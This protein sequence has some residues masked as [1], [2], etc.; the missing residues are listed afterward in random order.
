MARAG[1]KTPSAGIGPVLVRSGA[2][3][4]ALALLLAFGAAPP[5]AC[6]ALFGPV[7]TRATGIEEV[8]E[9][10]DCVDIVQSARFTAPVAVQVRGLELA[11]TD[12]ATH[13]ATLRV[14]AELASTCAPGLYRVAAGSAVGDMQV[15]AVLQTSLLLLDGE[16]LAFLSLPGQPAPVFRM[17]WESPWRLVSTPSESSATAVSP[18]ADPRSAPGYRPSS[19]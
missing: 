1:R 19:E 6:P 3:T 4:P 8:F 13:V 2:V 12:P 11:G 18:N 9:G 16:R 15:L 10:P 14:T 17:T 5:G 7:A